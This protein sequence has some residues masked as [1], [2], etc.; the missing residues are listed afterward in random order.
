MTIT[1]LAALPAPAP[2]TKDP[3]AARSSAGRA[4]PGD[5]AEW[6]RDIRAIISAYEVTPGL[7]CPSVT[8]GLAA[9]SFADLADAQ[10][11]RWGV[12]WA[13]TILSYALKVDFGRQDGTGPYYI[14]AGKMGSGLRVHIVAKASH[15]ADPETP[16]G[17]A[18]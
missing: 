8:A 3:R 6:A 2:S 7:P 16:A 1:D 17:R 12:A 11:A 13:E 10:E 18:A 14:L 5:R 15:Y 9:F 4:A